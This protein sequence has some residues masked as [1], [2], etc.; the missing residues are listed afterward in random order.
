MCGGPKTVAQ[1]SA[2]GKWMQMDVHP[3]NWKIIPDTTMEKN[4][5]ISNRSEAVNVQ[6]SVTAC[7]SLH[8]P[9]ANV[10]AS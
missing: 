1:N 10:E 3:V 4:K 2:I 8:G 7:T 5:N 6:L 9:N